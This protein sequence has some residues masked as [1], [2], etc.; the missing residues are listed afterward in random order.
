MNYDG[1]TPVSSF[2]QIPRRLQSLFFLYYS[3]NDYE[4]RRRLYSAVFSFSDAV[5]FF[6]FRMLS[7]FF[8]FGYYLGNVSTVSLPSFPFFPS[9]FYGA[10]ELEGIMRS[11][12]FDGNYWTVGIFYLDGFI[13]LGSVFAGFNGTG[14]N[15]P[16]TT[17]FSP[18]WTF[19]TKKWRHGY[20]KNWKFPRNSRKSR[21]KWLE[22]EA[23]SGI[24]LLLLLQYVLVAELEP[25]TSP[26]HSSEELEFADRKIFI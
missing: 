6:P 22:S 2:R 12:F 23:S 3:S 19:F 17:D 14:F 10:A 7:H 5:T 1:F 21:S 15:P 20:P 9:V 8:L 11:T 18:L 26:W 24:L 16:K 4:L 25:R 13:I